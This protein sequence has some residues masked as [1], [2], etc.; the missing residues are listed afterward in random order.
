[1]LSFFKTFIHTR[2]FLSRVRFYKSKHQSFSQ[3]EFIHLKDNCLQET[4]STKMLLTEQSPFVTKHSY[5]NQSL[6]FPRSLTL[7]VWF[8][9]QS[10]FYIFP[11]LPELNHLATANQKNSDEWKN[12]QHFNL[13]I[14]SNILDIT[15]YLKII[16]W[17][18][19]RQ[20]MY[21]SFFINLKK[22]C[23][24]NIFMYNTWT[25]ERSYQLSFA[26]K[27]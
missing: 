2:I 24:H 14:E 26:E 21:N 10:L 8:E 5:K 3:L 16:R 19:Q 12:K 4:H 20:N 18:W 9:S 1:M 23:M 25:I 22:K 11:T 27:T 13:F 15:T 7:P 6:S 17:F